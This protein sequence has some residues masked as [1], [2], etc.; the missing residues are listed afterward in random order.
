MF[1]VEAVNMIALRDD[2]GLYVA[3]EWHII[4]CFLVPFIDNEFYRLM[5]RSIVDFTQ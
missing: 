3:C 5:N 4:V 1:D 2:F